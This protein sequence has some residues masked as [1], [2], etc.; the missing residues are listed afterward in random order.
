[1]T[2]EENN[3]YVLEIKDLSFTQYGVYNL[4]IPSKF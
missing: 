2:I 1:M 4:L 3:T